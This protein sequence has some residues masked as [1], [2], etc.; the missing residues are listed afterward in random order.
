[1]ENIIEILKA[2]NEWCFQFFLNDED[3]DKFEEIRNVLN[4]EFEEMDEDLLVYML[5]EL[6][7]IHVCC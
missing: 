4:N 5:D 7:K 2:M 3:F 6:D 1:M